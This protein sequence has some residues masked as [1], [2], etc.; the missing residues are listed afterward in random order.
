MTL[1]AHHGRNQED[2]TFIPLV[3]DD[4]PVH[5]LT[6]TG[7]DAIEDGTGRGSPLVPLIGS[8]RVVVRKL[9]PLEKER[10]QGFPDGWTLTSNGKPQSDSA[11]SEELGNA[12]AVP[13]VEWIARRLAAVDG[14]M[15]EARAA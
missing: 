8:S 1:L 6:S 14:N 7:H 4:G 10:L 12:V 11:R 15:L 5:S 3:L 2:E 9:T 13:V